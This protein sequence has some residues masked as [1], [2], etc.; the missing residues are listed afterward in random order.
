[1]FAKLKYIVL[2]VLAAS[3]VALTPSTSRALPALQ[4][5]IE[6]GGYDF[7]TDTIVAGDDAF[8][9]YAFLNPSKYNIL[10]DMFY[11]SIAVL[12]AMEYS[13]EGDRLGSFTINGA[14]INV[15]SDMTYGTPPV[16]EIYTGLSETNDWDT[17][18]LEPH[19]VFPTYF[20]E[21]GFY[22]NENDM[23]ERYDTMYR[24]IDGEK[25]LQDGLMYY[26]AFTID[27]SLLDPEHVIHFDLYNSKLRRSGDDYDITM[28]AP[29]SHDAESRR[30]PEPGTL[31]LLGSG[32][33]GIYV[34]GRLRRKRA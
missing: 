27:T 25:T 24:A 32:L 28:F 6:D 15:T 34:H 7:S 19:G 4:L 33:V 3:V 10:T 2:A 11:I 29:F 23:T 31:I 14:T 20:Y 1:M 17:G 22:F 16:D 30:V 5:D 8:T 18:D 26:A 9:L 13:L 12:P 21:Y